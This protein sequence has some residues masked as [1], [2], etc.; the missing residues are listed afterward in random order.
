MPSRT[1]HYCVTGLI[2]LLSALHAQQPPQGNAPPS[3]PPKP[4][5]PVAASTLVARPDPY[6]GE[7]VS[8]AGVVD[9]SLSRTVFSVD[10]DRK[11]SS[12]K[13]VLVVA[14]TLQRNVEPNTY[15]T[16]IGEV[17]RFDQE[18][19]APKLKEYKLD[20]PA[21]VAA[22]Y[23]GKPAVIATNVI[24]GAGN[25][26]ARRLPPPMTA[27]EEAY[28]KLMKEVGSA[29]AALR[30]A[31][32][33]SDVKLAAEQSAG[34]RKTFIDVE[35][36]WRARRRNDAMHWAQ[37]ARK[38][39]ENVERSVAA[40]RWDDVKSHAATLG[41]ACQACHGVHRE[42]FDDGSFRIKKNPS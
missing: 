22:T 21:D 12:G 36:F 24:D 25:D 11:T 13:D 8:L 30:K 6:I 32:E 1:C 35:A 5:V 19:L 2:A 7:P 29:N 33:A 15:I 10:Q 20:L 14:P 39:S 34:L 3:P 23:I 40:A 16:V 41:K 18:A 31:I 9:R 42:R 4:L 27:E 38:A 26:L 28:Q 17:V 37:D